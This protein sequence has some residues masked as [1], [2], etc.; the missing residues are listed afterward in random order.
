MKIIFIDK[1]LI[2]SSFI[3]NLVQFNIL[4]MKLIIRCSRVDK[5]SS[6]SLGSHDY[7]V[8]LPIIRLFWFSIW[9][10]NGDANIFWK[11]H[12]ISETLLADLPETIGAPVLHL[13]Y[14]FSSV[15]YEFEDLTYLSYHLC[16]FNLIYEPF[17]AWPK[18]YVECANQFRGRK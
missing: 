10:S 12:S 3:D 13:T 18:I 16:K 5:V 9:Y 6:S 15:W 17:L 2:P 14:F 4:N 1:I 11:L 8:I 7:V